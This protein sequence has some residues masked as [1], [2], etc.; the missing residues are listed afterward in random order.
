LKKQGFQKENAQRILQ[1]WKEGGAESPEQL[2]RLF[3]RGSLRPLAVVLLQLVLDAGATYGSFVFAASI[4]RLPGLPLPALVS[5]LGTFA[6]FY[7]LT[8]AAFDIVTLGTILWSIYRFGTNAE[9]FMKALESIA[10]G[11]DITVIGKAKTIVDAFK[12]IQALNQIADILRE[13]GTGEITSLENLSAYLTLSHAENNYGFKPEKYGLSE[14]EATN[15]AVIFSRY[16][17]NDDGVLQ[18]S[19]L[20]N[21][22]TE[23]GTPLEEEELNAAM[24]VIDTDSSGVIEFEEFVDWW[25]NKVKPD[26]A[27]VIQT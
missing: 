7:F 17:Q 23:L 26:R 9:A 14:K 24:K 18:T 5:A 22:A 2:R 10:G 25:V 16:D 19:E 21:L 13:K 27:E 3:L 1:L 4:T 11:P 20:G 15:I 6:G 12:V 8:S